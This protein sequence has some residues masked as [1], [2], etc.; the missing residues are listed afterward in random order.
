[1]TSKIF[2][3]ARATSFAKYMI[4]ANWGWLGGL[5]TELSPTQA[6]P[7]QV[8]GGHTPVAQMSFA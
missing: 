8:A 4:R 1:M 5:R 2:G 3:L 6:N 7:F